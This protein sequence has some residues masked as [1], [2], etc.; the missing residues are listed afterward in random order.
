MIRLKSK[1]TGMD[2][3]CFKHQKNIKLESGNY[4]ISDYPIPNKEQFVTLLKDMEDVENRMNQI[5]EV[6]YKTCIDSIL[7]FPT[8]Q[9]SILRYLE[10]VFG[11]ENCWIYYFVCELEFGKKWQ[12][13]MITDNGKDC[14][15]STSEELYD[16]LLENLKK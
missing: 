13:G 6:L 10:Q 15:L 2:I 12:P 11:D 3:S 1:D 7:F 8:L 14:K 16:F 4:E 9:D 5:N